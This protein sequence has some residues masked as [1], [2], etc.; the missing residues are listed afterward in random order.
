MTN[1]VQLFP[2]RPNHAVTSQE[3]EELLN[4]I[5]EMARE[6]KIAQLAGAATLTNGSI[7]T[8]MTRTDVE[9]FKLAGALDQ[10]KTRVLLRTE[11]VKGER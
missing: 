2:E 8:F 9:P 1:I 3:T 6:G 7:V 11:A 5:I 10:M 4:Q